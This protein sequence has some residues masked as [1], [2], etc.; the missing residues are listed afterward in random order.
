ML[1]TILDIVS[2]ILDVTII[3]LIISKWKRGNNN[4]Q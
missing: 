1:S 2:I 3:V 4:E